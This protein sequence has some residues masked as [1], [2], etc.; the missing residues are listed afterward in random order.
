MIASPS[1]AAAQRQL[2]EAI[3]SVE[4]A[5]ANGGT[6]TAQCHLLEAICSAEEAAAAANGTEPEAQTAATAAS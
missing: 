2:R 1:R 4:E 5:A 6:K 3:R